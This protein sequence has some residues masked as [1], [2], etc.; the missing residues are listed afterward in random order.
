M[1]R[2]VLQLQEVPA[3]REGFLNSLLEQ[4]VPVVQADL[5][6]QAVQLLL[7]ILENQESLENHVGPLLQCRL[8]VL[9]ALCH[10]QSSVT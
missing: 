1:L 3:A 6:D 8:A 2:L 7:G 4:T 10:T 9:V 5:L